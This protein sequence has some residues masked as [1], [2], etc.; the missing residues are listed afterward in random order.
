[1]I[2]WPRMEHYRSP[3]EVASDSSLQRKCG[4]S[5]KEPWGKLEQTMFG[6]ERRQLV[7]MG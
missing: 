4:I 6:V 2:H 1:M 7:E 3:F 5:V